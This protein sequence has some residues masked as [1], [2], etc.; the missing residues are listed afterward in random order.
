MV[1][2]EHYCW[3]I[4]IPQLPGVTITKQE[5]HPVVADSENVWNG[6]EQQQQS[7]SLNQ[8][9]QKSTPCHGC[10]AHMRL[11][12]PIHEERIF[13][14]PNLADR[15][16]SWERKYYHGVILMNVVTIIILRGIYHVY[17]GMIIRKTNKCSSVMM[18][19]RSRDE[20]TRS[21][22]CAADNEL[23]FGD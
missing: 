12:P 3:A 8:P 4:T 22:A 19:S 11:I 9:F 2:L 16:T 20:W 6:W 17:G 14:I 1:R 13:E 18:M 10:Q 23:A 5:L 21:P 15:C 7:L